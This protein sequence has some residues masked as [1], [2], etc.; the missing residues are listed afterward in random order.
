RRLI[1]DVA[2]RLSLWELWAGRDPKEL[3]ERAVGL[4]EPK[5]GLLS[6]QSPRMPFALWRMYQGRL[7]DA[8]EIFERLFAEAVAHGDEI[9][10]LGV[11]GRL[12]DVALRMGGWARLQHTPTTPTSLPSK[13]AWNTT[14]AFPRIGRRLPPHIWGGWTRRA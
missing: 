9:A 1:L 5:D 12:V 10:G 4:E 13:S 14:V 8:R 7:D 11:R 3:L 2:A 6:Y